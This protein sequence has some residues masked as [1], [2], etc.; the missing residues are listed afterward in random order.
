M[1]VSKRFVECYK[2]YGIPFL[3]KMRD[4]ERLATECEKYNL[5]PMVFVPLIY[6]L[7]GRRD[8]A[9]KYLEK[10]MKSFLRLKEP[11]CLGQWNSCCRFEEFYAKFKDYA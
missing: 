7:A 1:I 6:L 2:E 9:M 11:P 8:R 10:Q 5:V 3:E 4:P